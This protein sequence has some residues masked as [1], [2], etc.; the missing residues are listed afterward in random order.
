MHFKI[1]AITSNQHSKYI[2]IYIWYLIDI[3]N[4]KQVHNFW[5]NC[6]APSMVP[7]SFLLEGSKALMRKVDSP[8]KKNKKNII[9]NIVI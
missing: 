1:L 9:E 7:S 4:P 6:L 2:Y 5:C 3:K 8:Y